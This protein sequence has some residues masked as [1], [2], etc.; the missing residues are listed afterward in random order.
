M[1][2]NKENKELQEQINSLREQELSLTKEL[3]T[4]RSTLASISEKDAKNLEKIK[5]L[6][7][8]ILDLEN[9]ADNVSKQI[10]DT[11]GQILTTQQEIVDSREEERDVSDDLLDNDKTRLLLT[12][13]QKKI[14]DQ[15]DDVYDSTVDL[16][17]KLLQTQGL[18]E[19][20]VQRIKAINESSTAEQSAFNVLLEQNV[21][22]RN[23]ILKVM[24]S[25]ATAGSE[26]L[27]LED[28][29]NAAQDAAAQGRFEIIDT[30]HAENALKDIRNKIDK[31]GNSLT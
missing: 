17:G 16:A 22:S 1:A 24:R 10:V 9:K 6:K 20:S 30:Q 21:G 12:D 28:Q 27:K 14:Y 7:E 5:S 13:K 26:M 25:S 15:I 8:K 18:S 29:I 3:V 19:K 11:Q 23:E 31:E 4:L 2:D